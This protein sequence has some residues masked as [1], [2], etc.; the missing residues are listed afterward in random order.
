[1]KN[2]LPFI[3]IIIASLF[4]NCKI[5]Q[6]EEVELVLDSKSELGE[7]AIWN[8]KTDKLLWVDITGKILNFYDPKLH[9]NKEVHTGQMIGTVVPAESGKVIAALENGFYQLDIETGEKLFIANPEE[10]IEGNRFN[11]GKCDPAGRLWAGTMSMKGKKHAGA[12]YRLD[13]DGSIHKMID[14]VTTSNG[15]A[16]S[17]DAT[18]LPGQA[19]AKKIL[20]NF[21]KQEAFS[22]LNRVQKG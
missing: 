1:M 21:H 22:K 19:Q 18:K 20:K 12:L 3:I 4:V 11:D 7:G 6:K 2:I 9:I 5:S 16:W 17:L 8:Y 10:N 13:P 14:S 15:I